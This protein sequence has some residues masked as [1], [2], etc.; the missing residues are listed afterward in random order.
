M[1]VYSVHLTPSVVQCL[2][3]ANGQSPLTKSCGQGSSERPGTGRLSWS[4]H[5]G[6]L[7]LRCRCVWMCTWD[8]PLSGW[9]FWLEAEAWIAQWSYLRDSIS[10]RSDL[11]H[12]LMLTISS[13]IEM[14]S[15]SFL[16]TENAG[17][18]SFCHYTRL[19]GR[20]V[21]ELHIPESFSAASCSLLKSLWLAPI[22]AP[23]IGFLPPANRDTGE[24]AGWTSVLC[25]SAHITLDSV[26]KTGKGGESPP[27]TWQAHFSL[28]E[29][30]LPAWLCQCKSQAATIA[31]APTTYGPH[32]HSRIVSKVQVLFFLD[33]EKKM[34]VGKCDFPFCILLFVQVL[35]YRMA[36][37]LL[38]VREQ[39]GMVNLPTRSQ[40]KYKW[41]R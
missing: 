12:H 41:R 26:S 14:E 10:L 4:P 36:R 28:T 31:G 9:M 8:P 16:P 17:V 40:I 13:G 11:L 38:T 3:P 34:Q 29:E 6:T 1:S 39:E 7:H 33:G 22:T 25:E 27:Q 21:L 2:F 37:F 24:A 15:F 32:H 23:L 30:P 19:W 5:T 20:S 35:F 18:G